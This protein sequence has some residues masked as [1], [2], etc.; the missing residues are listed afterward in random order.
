[1]RILVVD[2]Y[3]PFGRSLLLLLKSEHAVVLCAGGREALAL[4]E[5]DRAF[6]LILCDLAMHDGSGI[7][8]WRALRSTGDDRKIVFMTGG[9]TLPEATEFLAAVE[10]TCL[11]K[12]FSP[13]ELRQLLRDRSPD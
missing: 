3:A 5:H 11:E 9:P 2:D 7:D 13:E 8:V 6:D 1:M 10:N 12:P 4:L